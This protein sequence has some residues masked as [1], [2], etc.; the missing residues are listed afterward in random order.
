MIIVITF[1]Y[2]G[3]LSASMASLSRGIFTQSINPT[4]PMVDPIAPISKSEQVIADVLKGAFSH[5]AEQLAKGIHS[6]LDL[7]IVDESEREAADAKLRQAEQSLAQLNQ[8]ITAKEASLTAMSQT[9]LVSQSPQPGQLTKPKTSLEL[10]GMSFARKA[11]LLLTTTHASDIAS[12]REMIGHNLSR[13]PD[14]STAL[15]LRLQREVTQRDLD[16]KL[17]MLKDEATPIA[18]KGTLIEAIEIAK[19]E[20]AAIEETVSQRL[21]SLKSM[22]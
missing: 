5:L 8:Q 14:V 21:L 17:A 9:L 16:G 22:Y 11:E 2:I 1:A 19:S 3:E 10:S 7:P 15:F 6:N 12:I 4:P 20:L 18:Q 13:Q